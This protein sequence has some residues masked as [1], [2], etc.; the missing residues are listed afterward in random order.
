MREL[1][2]STDR[3][4]ACARE[5]DVV[6]ERTRVISAVRGKKAEW[7]ARCNPDGF[8]KR[9]YL[10]RTVACFVALAPALAIGCS[11]TF[12]IPAEFFDGGSGNT[13][14]TPAV[15]HHVAGVGVTTLAGSDVAGAQDGSGANAQFNN[16]VGV[17]IDPQGNLLVTE[18]DGNRVRKVTPNGDVGM[19]SASV[20]EPFALA[21]A[22]GGI[23]VV[24]TDYN[25]KGEKTN[26]SGT[27]WNVA[28]NGAATLMVAG[29]GRPRGLAALADGRVA[30]V[31]HFTHTVSL[32]DPATSQMTLL[33]GS[34]GQAGF[35]DASGGNARFDTPYGAAVFADGRILVADSNNFRLR[36]IAPDGTVATFAG[37]GANGM[38]DG[39][40]LQAQIGNVR[41]VAIDTA[42]VVYFTDLGNHYIRRVNLAG[43]VETLAGDGTAAFQD[44]TGETA[45]FYGQEG[46][47][48]TPDGKT[49]YV[50][51]GTVGNPKLPYNRVRKVMV[52]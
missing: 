24:Q 39:P 15:V 30:V 22:T 25:E 6:A 47:D 41:G 43:E 40:R 5:C 52:P 38:V 4:V 2:R 19:L 51:D 37:N 8:M 7:Y 3:Y 33:A 46:L 1:E 21:M 42:G 29:L 50:A 49:V 17:T 32:L 18:Y 10:Q 11:D 14:T 44:G 45:R 35:A 9:L 27:L 26:T 28:P 36:T 48:V 13:A 12:A 16:P 23:L 34:P 20:T 31:D